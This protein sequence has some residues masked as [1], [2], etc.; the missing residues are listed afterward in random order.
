MNRAQDEKCLWTWIWTKDGANEIVPEEPEP[1]P[2][3]PETVE[4]E[5]VPEPPPHSGTCHY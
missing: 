1:E 3:E 5:R 2:V 4:V